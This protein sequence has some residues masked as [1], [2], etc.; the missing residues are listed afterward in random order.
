VLVGLFMGALLL[1]AQHVRYLIVK[2][3][4]KEKRSPSLPDH[5]ELPPPIEEELK[6]R[7]KHA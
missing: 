4:L 1:L 3:F 2:H 7:R 5:I 6:K